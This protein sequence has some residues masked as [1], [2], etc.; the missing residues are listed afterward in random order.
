MK[1]LN[2]SVMD[3]AEEPQCLT[4]LAESINAE[5]RE[6]TDCVRRSLIHA[7]KAGEWLIKAKEIIG[8]GGWLAWLEDNTEF[9]DRTAQVY[10]RVARSWDEIE[11]QARAN[12]QDLADLGIQS[13]LTLLAK[14]KSE[15]EPDLLPL[16]AKKS[17]SWCDKDEDSEA[18]P[19]PTVETSEKALGISRFKA[20]EEDGDEYEVEVVDPSYRHDSMSE[21]EVRAFHT[22]LVAVVNRVDGLSKD[23]ALLPKDHEL[24]DSVQSLVDDLASHLSTF[25][26]VLGGE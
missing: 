21:A 23:A 18:F 6:A 24:L 9:P 4:S 22:S 14:P 20:T 1:E 17:K 10:M 16:T 19:R 13:A 7:R 3:V 2:L 12:A 15:L 8:H 26:E 11:T 25:R 5:H